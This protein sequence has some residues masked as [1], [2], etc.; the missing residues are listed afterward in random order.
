[1]KRKLRIKAIRDGFS[2]WDAPE[3]ANGISAATRTHCTR[4][5]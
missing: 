1:M 4:G 5:I 3:N 2:G